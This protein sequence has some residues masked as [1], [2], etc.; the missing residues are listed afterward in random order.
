M[1]LYVGVT[2][3]WIFLLWHLG[4]HVIVES[5]SPAGEKRKSGDTVSR[6]GSI[7]DKIIY[8]VQSC[9]NLHVLP[10]TSSLLSS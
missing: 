9:I 4:M 8:H 1:V 10:L 7:Y 6:L 3:V 2:T 5:A